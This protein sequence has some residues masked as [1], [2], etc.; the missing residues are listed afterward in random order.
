MKGTLQVPTGD[1]LPGGRKIP[2]YIGWVQSRQATEA[3][4][5]GQSGA[6]GIREGLSEEAARRLK[7]E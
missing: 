3:N 1:T 6:A 5:T 2:K 7:P 4:V